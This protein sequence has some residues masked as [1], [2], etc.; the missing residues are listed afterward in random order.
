MSNSKSS[1]DFHDILNKDNDKYLDELLAE[2]PIANSELNKLM[3]RAV[4]DG[5]NKC[6]LV[7][8]KRGANPNTELPM[9]E[10]ILTW[11]ISNGNAEACSILTQNGINVNKST[12]IANAT[13]LM[14][15][16]QSGNLEIINLLISA[17][18]RLNDC[19]K[20]G[21]TALMIA[22]EAGKDEAVSRLRELSDAVESSP[23]SAS[24]RRT[25][26]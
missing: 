8:L 12:T 24:Q 26:G 20:A 23:P 6:L 13:P 7:L 9:G 21:K 4:L 5:H 16:A 18:A 10:N 17:G 19:T 22:T 3:F 25:F 14:S 11:A 2:S 1:N 15:A